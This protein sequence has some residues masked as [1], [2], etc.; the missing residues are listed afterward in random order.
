MRYECKQCGTEFTKDWGPASCPKCGSKDLWITGGE[1]R[2][3][4]I[5]LAACLGVLAVML[6][7]LLLPLEALWGGYGAALK[8]GAVI[9]GVV[10]FLVAFPISVWS[11]LKRRKREHR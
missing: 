3:I 6:C 4:L 10:A 11:I 2:A 8:L 5:V 1:T 9:G 7:C